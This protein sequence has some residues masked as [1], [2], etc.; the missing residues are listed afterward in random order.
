[1]FNRLSLLVNGANVYHR[2]KNY[3][4]LLILFCFVISGE[5]SS[6]AQ[7]THVFFSLSRNLSRLNVDALACACNCLSPNLSHLVVVMIFE[8]SSIF[9]FISYPV[10]FCVFITYKLVDFN[11]LFFDRHFENLAVF[12]IA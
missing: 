9:N 5:G 6:V 2:L 12:F 8:I 3:L 4:T 1:M 11:L 7:L 10:L